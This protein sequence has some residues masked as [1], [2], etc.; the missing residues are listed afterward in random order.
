MRADE[1]RYARRESTYVDISDMSESSLTTIPARV[2]LVT[3]SGYLAR[4]RTQAAAGTSCS[5]RSAA[6]SSCFSKSTSRSAASSTGRSVLPRSCS[7]ASSCAS[8]VGLG[9]GLGLGLGVGLGL[10]LGLG[11]G[12]S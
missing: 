2:S 4:G 6:A 11:L 8:E 3:L 12:V 7:V 10:G 5:S 9:L 1:A